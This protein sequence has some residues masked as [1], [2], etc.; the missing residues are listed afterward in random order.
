MNIKK[1]YNIKCILNKYNI[2]ISNDGTILNYKNKK[3]ISKFNYNNEI[4]I[5][6]LNISYFDKYLKDECEEFFLKIVDKILINITNFSYKY[7]T[8]IY[9]LTHEDFNIIKPILMPNENMDF[10]GIRLVNQNIILS[11]TNQKIISLFRL[12]FHEIAHSFFKCENLFTDEFNAMNFEIKALNKLMEA[13]S[14]KYIK[15]STNHDNY[16]PYDSIHYKA[17]EKAL[18]FNLTEQNNYIKK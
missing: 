5:K 4:F 14:T 7:F 18:K 10:D 1:F 16:L 8:D 3:I 15:Y 17:Y 11:H 2:K 6:N 13:I 9:F 12:I